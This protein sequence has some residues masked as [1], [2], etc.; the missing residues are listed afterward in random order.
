MGAALSPPTSPPLPLLAPGSYFFP[1]KNNSLL[2][3]LHTCFSSPFHSNLP[4]S[5]PHLL[6]YF[7]ATPFP[8]LNP[9]SASV[10]APHSTGTLLPSCGQSL[11]IP[12][13]EVQV[14]LPSTWEGY[15]SLDLCASPESRLGLCSDSA[16]VACAVASMLE[17]SQLGPCLRSRHVLLSSL[18][19]WEAPH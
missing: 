2:T 5:G 19:L 13:L 11:Y 4:K 15:S 17:S 8:L 18:S 14:F 6:F 1:L 10:P 7:L 12:A 3:S 16:P 9:L